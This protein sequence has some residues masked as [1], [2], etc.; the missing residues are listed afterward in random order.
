MLK[1]RFLAAVGIKTLTAQVTEHCK[2]LG[3]PDD[4]ANEAATDA[5]RLAQGNE[6]LNPTALH[7]VLSEVCRTA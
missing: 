2:S 4:A 1:E 6:A 5:V 7:E 3:W